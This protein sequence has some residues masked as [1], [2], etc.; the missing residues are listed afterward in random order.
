MTDLKECPFCLEE[1]PAKAIKCR[2]C[3]SLVDDVKPATFKADGPAES[4]AAQEPGQDVPQQG[5]Y[6][7]AASKEKKG[8]RSVVALVVVLALV[9]FLGA[10]GAGYWFFFH[11]RGEPVAEEFVDSEL[12]GTWKR[13]SGSELYFQFLPNDMVNVAVPGEGYWFR[14]QYRISREDSKSLLELYHRNHGEWEATAELARRDAETITMTD[15]WAGVI[16]DL[17]RFPEPEFRE[18]IND[19][20][21]ER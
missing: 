15:T 5:V 16:V 6:Y 7:Q 19:L 13:T 10:A 3:E 2:F 12:I 14:T 20:R 8:G 1:I 11:D 4:D 17:E 9:L 21:F 18:V